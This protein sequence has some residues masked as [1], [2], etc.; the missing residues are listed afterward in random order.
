MGGV[1]VIGLFVQFGSEMCEALRLC[2]AQMLM[3]N[4]ALHQFEVLRLMSSACVLFLVVGIWLM[5]WSRFVEHRAWERVVAHPHWY[6][7]AGALQL[8]T[9]HVVPAP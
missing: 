8:Q 9:L 5:E 2:L 7:G 4:M 1:S 6:L 3:C